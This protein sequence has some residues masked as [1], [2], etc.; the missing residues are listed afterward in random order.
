M[1]TN[2]TITVA[3][4]A[5]Q[6]QLRPDALAPG[7]ARAASGGRCGTGGAGA[8]DVRVTSAAPSLGPPQFTQNFAAAELG[9]SHHVH[10]QSTPT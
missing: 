2:A 10:A 7:L 6:R 1:V 9:D 3:T 8:S 5:N 4:P